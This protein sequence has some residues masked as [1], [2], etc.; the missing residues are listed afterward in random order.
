MTFFAN[1]EH[2]PPSRPPRVDFARLEH[3][4][5]L[6]HGVPTSRRLA[7]VANL[8]SRPQIPKII[9]GVKKRVLS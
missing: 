6:L 4:R 2:R 5:H 9:Q 8:S 7:A 3:S 1:R